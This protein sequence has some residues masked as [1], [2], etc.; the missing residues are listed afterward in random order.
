MAFV[1]LFDPTQQFMGRPSKLL[2]GGNLYVYRNGTDDLATVKNIAGTTISQPVVL[3]C[4]GRAQGGVCVPSSGKYR[5]EVRD[6]YGALQW[7]ITGMSAIGGGEGGGSDVSITPAYNSGLKIAD[8][9]IDGESGELFAPTGGGGLQIKESIFEM[10][11]DWL[12]TTSDWVLRPNT[13]VKMRTSQSVVVQASLQEAFRFF[14]SKK[15]NVL[16]IR[17][18]DEKEEMTGL[19]SG[20]ALIKTNGSIPIQTSWTDFVYYSGNLFKASPAYNETPQK[21]LYVY[22]KDVYRGEIYRP[23]S[24]VNLVTTDSICRIQYI[25]STNTSNPYG[26][27]V[28]AILTTADSVGIYLDSLAFTTVPT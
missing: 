7:S 16:Y 5:L 21:T 6:A 20:N 9:S 12:D 17:G 24:N 8:Y 15:L 14:Y 22:P 23:M 11:D 3:D 4:D 10:A 1:P 25:G 27:G 26:I 18:I 13:I 28:R 2:V 19:S